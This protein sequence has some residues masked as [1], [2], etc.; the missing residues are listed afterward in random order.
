[1]FKDYPGE[2]YAARKDSPM[3]IG[4]TGG[5]SYLASD[6]PAILKYTRNV[7][8]IG[9]MELARLTKGAV[10]FYNLDGEEIQKEMKTIEWDA[11][12][13]EKSGYEHFMLKEIHEKPKVIKD[14]INSVLTDGNISFESV[15]LS[16]EDMKNIQ[17]V[18]IV[19]CGS[20]YHVGMVAQY[21][22]EELTSLSV[23][24]ELA[25]EF[26]YRQMKLAKNSLAIII[27]QSGETA[28]SL[29]ALRL[30]KEKGVKTL[31]I[32]N[33]VGSSI[34]REA[35]MSSIPS[36]VLKY[37]SQQLKHIAV[38]LLPH[39]SLQCSLQ[40]QEGRYPTKDLLSSLR[41]LI[42]SLKR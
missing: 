17:Q 3:I 27:S 18:Y 1:M 25:S 21:V 36:Q 42:L 34:A 39:I 12:A 6:V 26:R 11:E 15:G 33:V 28:D 8:Y 9:N 20:A 38:S 29:A 35:E 31:G 32:V 19:A 4:V 14:T 10:A 5:E 2:I 30:C 16:D 13:A 23:R 37:L 24:V 40:K 41:R 22:I 7:Y